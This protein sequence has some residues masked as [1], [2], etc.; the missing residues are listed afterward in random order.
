MRHTDGQKF[1]NRGI[2]KSRSG[3]ILFVLGV[4]DGPVISLN[5]YIIS[6]PKSIP[7]DLD[8]F[9][10][11]TKSLISSIFPTHSQLTLTQFRQTKT[12]ACCLTE[13]ETHTKSSACLLKTLCSVL[14]RSCILTSINLLDINL[15]WSLI[16]TVLSLGEKELSETNF[17][18]PTRHSS[19]GSLGCTGKK[20]G[21]QSLKVLILSTA[22]S[23][24]VIL[25]IN[26]KRKISN[27]AII[28]S[29]SSENLETISLDGGLIQNFGRSKLLV[30]WHR[31][32]RQGCFINFATGR[33]IE[34]R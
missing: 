12:C 24:Y 23:L 14:K 27:S 30:Y 18:F 4:N 20:V 5:S 29:L 2:C 1:E 26:Q 6:I 3:S 15:R 21:I 17:L 34:S 25:Q 22:S 7:G 28:K 9:V 33:L 8:S 11:T 32:W 31:W 19:H 10:S 13:H 16:F